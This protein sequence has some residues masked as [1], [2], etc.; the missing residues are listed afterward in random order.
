MALI[1]YCRACLEGLRFQGG[2]MPKHCT[3]C[4]FGKQPEDMRV[5]LTAEELPDPRQPYRVT[6]ND[7]RFLKSLRIDPEVV[8]PPV[9]GTVES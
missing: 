2:E 5:W 3:R 6:Y 9:V 8:P 1:L 7:A 4:G